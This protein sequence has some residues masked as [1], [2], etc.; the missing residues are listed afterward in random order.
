MDEEQKDFY[1]KTLRLRY[2]AQQFKN[3]DQLK[4]GI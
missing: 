1:Q 2:Q 4:N 3:I